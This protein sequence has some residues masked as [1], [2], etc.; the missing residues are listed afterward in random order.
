MLNNFYGPHSRRIILQFSLFFQ[1]ATVMILPK[2]STF[3]AEKLHIIKND[4]TQRGAF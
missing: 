4:T 1:K 2:A 3:P